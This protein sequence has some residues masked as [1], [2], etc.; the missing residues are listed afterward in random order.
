MT[1]HQFELQCPTIDAF[2]EV[3]INYS[4]SEITLKYPI[5]E[6]QKPLVINVQF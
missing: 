5:L 2:Q 6:A 1:H 4:K 3:K